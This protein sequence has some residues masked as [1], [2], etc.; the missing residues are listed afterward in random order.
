[1]AFRRRPGEPAL[2]AEVLGGLGQGGVGPNAARVLAAGCGNCLSVSALF[3][4]RKAR[5]GVRGMGTNLQASMAPWCEF[6]R[7]RLRLDPAA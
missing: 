6:E 7:G 5:V 4:L 3:C 1:M 2:V